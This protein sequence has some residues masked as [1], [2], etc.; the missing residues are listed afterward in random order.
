MARF[1]DKEAGLMKPPPEL[2][3]IV[4][5]IA[6][7]VLADHV[8]TKIFSSIVSEEEIEDLEGMAKEISEY[9]K[10]FENED[11]E[12]LFEL[13]EDLL[14]DYHDVLRIVI[15]DTK[16]NTY[17]NKNIRDDA[18]LALTLFEKILSWNDLETLSNSDKSLKVLRDNKID[19]MKLSLC[20][21]Y[22]SKNLK[23]K[24]ES[25][26]YQD[27]DMF[28]LAQSRFPR[29]Y[30]KTSHTHIDLG[31]EARIT[32]PEFVYPIVLSFKFMD[33]NVLGTHSFRN[34]AH[35]I[36]IMIPEKTDYSRDDLAQV[37]GTVRHEL[38]HAVQSEI[39]QRE[40]L[41]DR[42][43]LPFKRRDTKITQH[44]KS[45]ERQVR[46]ELKDLGLD[47]NLANFHALDDVEFY[48]RLLDEVEEF[49]S[50]Y[51]RNP[52]LRKNNST[53]RRHINSS[54]FFRALKHFKRKSWD[55][56]VGLF[57]QAVT[58][59]SNTRV[60]RQLIQDL[61]GV[62]TWVS[63]SRQDGLD[64]DTSAPEPSRQDYEDGKS[65]R[66]RVLPLPSGHPKGRDEYRS[67][68]PVSNTP[69]DSSGAS[70]NYGK[71][72]NPNAL[73]NQPD[74][75]PLHQRPRSSGIP[76]D[77]Y[78]HPYVDANKTTGLARRPKMAQEERIAD[79][80]HR[81]RAKITLR[82]PRRKQRDTKGTLNRKNKIDYVKK[83]RRDLVQMKRDNKRYY[84]RNKTKL[85]LSGKR[86]RDNPKRYKRLEGGGSSTVTQKNQKSRK[87]QLR[88]KAMQREAVRSILSR[89]YRQIPVDSFQHINFI[90]RGAEN[91]PTDP[92]L[93][94]E[95]IDLAK[96]DRK[97]PVS[98]GD[99]II[100]PV[101]GG[102]GF[103]K[104]PSA[105]ANGWASKSYK[106]LGGG[107]R[108]KASEKD[109]ALSTLQ[110]LLAI[111]RG[112]HWA[113]W[114][115][116]WQV[117]GESQYGDHLL[118]E[119]IYQSLIEE[120]DTLAEKIVGTYGGRAVSPV[121]QAQLMANTILPIAEV[122][123]E[124]NPIL[125]ALIVEEA[126]QVA[127]K[128]IYKALKEMDVLTLGMDDFI[129]SMANAHETNL[130]LLRQ[131]V[132]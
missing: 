39:G 16:K 130:Y 77:Q 23:E 61:A 99:K 38:V 89:M 119:R 82:P 34:S 25:Y 42:G 64:N 52:I 21:L 125:R 54:P 93:W 56:A 27:K 83:K 123:A 7:G 105:Y 85:L 17:K 98:R 78:G 32:H 132:E 53:V 51:F 73:P 63:K 29:E 124:D 5:E 47:P 37:K 112:A 4:A 33:S 102:E 129:M 70:L 65:Q 59:D 28:E 86:R 97:N 116:H 43:G 6:Q 106:E 110:V 67:G 60:A 19:V 44:N 41:S 92:K 72:P 26:P 58:E 81:G 69:S 14:H 131:R 18:N 126:L 71:A 57:Y 115:S 48:T 12:E 55:K 103:R 62:Q 117:K 91:M 46:Q 122:Q 11:M 20:L 87:V 40:G 50:R 75:K 121:D 90:E 76:G 1:S 109:M 30:L 49:R 15:A 118:L 10:D 100:N 94:G 3:R 107:W 8:L 31:V 68:P 95:I 22:V 2:F 104:Y 36:K 128:N 80:K 66:D 111:L 45:K 108:K 113:H 13:L 84:L 120:I 9:L 35:H 96:G 24:K 127:F 101:R 74:G 79:P 114:T 88:K